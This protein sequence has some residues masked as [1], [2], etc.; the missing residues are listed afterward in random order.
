MFLSGHIL[1][2]TKVIAAYGIV[3]VVA[4]DLGIK[5]GKKQRDFVQKIPIQA[6][7]FFS[8]AYTVTNE[9]Y[10]SLI[11]VAI[12]LYLKYMYSG[13]KTSKVCFEEV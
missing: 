10:L 13:G 1:S 5:T 4:Q 12:Y 2:I 3:Q 7:I 6:I 11:T 8:T 9:V